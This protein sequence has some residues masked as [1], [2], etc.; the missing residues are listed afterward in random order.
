MK[1]L[2]RRQ[3][4][5]VKH[6]RIIDGHPWMQSKK[7]FVPVILR[8]QEGLSRKYSKQEIETGKYFMGDV[9]LLFGPAYRPVPEY[10]L[11]PSTEGGDICDF[12]E[13][14]ITQIVDRYWI[15]GHVQRIVRGHPWMVNDCL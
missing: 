14:A 15:N 13:D 2:T 5:R 11:D 4:A 7:D 8:D 10:S 12:F 3:Y 1:I 9:G 6:R